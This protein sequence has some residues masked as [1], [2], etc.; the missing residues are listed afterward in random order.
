M[1]R[2]GK[3]ILHGTGYTVLYLVIYYCLGSIFGAG[4]GAESVSVGAGRFFLTLLFGFSIA[5][6]N[7]LF[8]SLTLKPW[9]SRICAYLVS[10]LAFFCIIILGYRLNETPAKV[11]VGILIFTVF[12]FVIIGIST[13]VRRTL[14]DGTSKKPEKKKAAPNDKYTPRYK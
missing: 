2:L 9:L 13:L 11:F 8:K 14:F 3:L 4:I 10:T 7:F 5:M 1:E 6:T 12:Y